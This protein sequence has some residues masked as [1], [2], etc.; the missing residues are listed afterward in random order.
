MNATVNVICYSSKTLSNGENPLM[1]RVSK[2]GK[3]TYKSLGISVNPLFWDFTK[4]KPKRNCPNKEQIEQLIS[5]KKKTFTQT[6]LEL[7]TTKKEYT[8]NSLIDTVNKPFTLQTV[9]QV[10]LSQIEKLND[11]KRKGYAASCKQVYNSLL[12]YNKHLNIYFSDIDVT[13]LRNYE[14]WLRKQKIAENTIGIR[15]RTLR[16]MFNV[17]IEEKFVSSEYYPFHIFKVS[18]IHED[19]AK[20][21]LLKSDIGKI[22]EYTTDNERLQFSIDISMSLS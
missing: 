10:F 6:I 9:K 7:N 8:T 5:E 18:K 2:D 21:A 4:N 3:R 1:I 19:T 14:I 17:A 15:F 16:V 13:W 22:T 11:T 20:R 12:I